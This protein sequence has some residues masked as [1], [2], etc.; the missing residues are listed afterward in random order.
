[1]N[2]LGLFDGDRSL[3]HDLAEHERRRL[4]QVWR[5]ERS[6][7]TDRCRSCDAPILWC[8]T[9]AGKWQPLDAQPDPSGN[10]EIERRGCATVSRVVNNVAIVLG[11]ALAE[12]R[13]GQPIVRYMPHHATC[14]NADQWRR[15]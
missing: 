15:S 10:V 7:H 6:R 4:E 13:G 2:D 1:M 12:S 3:A 9:E 8:V 5:D 11:G 14:P